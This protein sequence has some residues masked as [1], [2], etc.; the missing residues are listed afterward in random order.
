MEVGRELVRP[1]PVET[2]EAITTE[3]PVAEGS[4]YDSWR[5][6]VAVYLVTRAGLIALAILSHFVFHSLVPHETLSGEFANWDGWWYIHLATYGYPAYVS[7]AQT[8]LGFF[9]LYSMAM[10]L[11]AHLFQSSYVV[12][13]MIISGLGG[14]VATLLVQRL[15]TDW[16][17]KEV[18]RKAVLL[19]CIFPGSIIFSMAYSEGLLIPLIAGCL[20]ALS[21]K[22][23]LLAGLL[24]AFA[25]GIGP[26]ALVM[27]PACAAPAVV[28]IRRHGWRDRRSLKSLVAPLLSPLGAVGFA[29]FLWAWTGSPFAN[30]IA[31]KDGWHESTNPLAVPIQFGV[32]LKEIGF[33]LHFSHI[34]VNVPVALAGSVFLA[35][36]LYWLWK[37]RETLP[38][39]VAVFTVF[40]SLLMVTSLHVPPN[41]RL[42][43]T[44]FPVVLVYAKRF[45]GRGWRWNLWLNW[46]CLIGL[47][48]ITYMGRLL[49]P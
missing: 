17:G 1:R 38:I 48:I 4:R 45:V 3:P 41:P 25:T 2:E 20:Y 14:L 7:H 37:D 30:F 36:G 24:A 28:A 10:W 33:G 47:S 15:V 19:F 44:G 16:W 49:R 40:I 8:T 11:V 32:L 34:N 23:Y 31:Q 39:E 13:G 12:A 6:P 35:F 42:L 26:D 21:R 18:A 22:R 5:Y 46:A 27:V 29:A 43:I 9:P